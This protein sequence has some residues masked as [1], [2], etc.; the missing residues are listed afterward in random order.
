MGKKLLSVFF[1]LSIFF[2]N[3][4]DGFGQCPT[5]LNISA[6]PGTTI[7]AGTEV[8]FTANPNGGT[9]LQYQWQVNGDNVSTNASYQTSALTNGQK[10][11][12]IVTSTTAGFTDCSITSNE[13]TITVNSLKTPTVAVTANKT[14]ICPGENVTFTASNTNGGT[15]PQYSFYLNNGNTALQTGTSNTYSTT[16]LNNGDSIRVLLTSKLECVTS[17][18]AEADSNSITVRAGTPVKPGSINASV[19]TEICPGTSQ[20]YSIS[21]VAGAT[22]YQWTLPSGWSGTSTSTSINA[23]AGTSGGTISVKAINGCGT[24]EVETLNI[25][26]KPGTPAVPANITGETA[27]CPGSS[28]TY[29]IA[30]VTN[31]SEYIWILPSGWS[32][33]SNT[34]SI[35]VTAGNSGSGS[36]SI[37]AKNDCGTSAAK[38]L[39][40]SIK[41]GTPAQPGT[42]SGTSEI[43]PGTQQTYSITAITGATSYIWTL[44]NGW[45][46]TSTTNSITVTSGTTGGNVTVKATNDCGTG[47]EQTLP[48]SVK[49]GTPVQ[50][51]AFSG[52]NLVCPNTSETFSISP[53]NGATEY[54]W[55]LPSGWTGSSTSESITVTTGQSGSGNITVK[56]KNDCGT[57]TA[58]IYSV[59][60]DKPAPVMTGTVTGPVEVCSTATGLVYSIPAITNATTYTWSLPSGWAITAGEGTRSI[61]VKANSAG[62]NVSVI[63]KNTCGESAASANFVVTSITGV[64]NTPGTITAPNLPSSAICPPATGI[65]FNVPAV[66]GAKSY[67]WTL[68]SG[69]EITSGSGTNAIVVKVNS[70]AAT[71][72]NASI[73]VEAINVCGNSSKST[74]SGI[75]IDSH[76]ITN[77]GADKTVCKGIASIDITGT[78]SFSGS[79]ANLKTLWS[80]PAGMGSFDNASKLVTKFI[81]TQ[82]AL[83]AGSV[84]LT[85]TTDAPS[86]ACGPGK[87]EMIIYFKPLPTATITATSPVCNGS[88]STLTFTGTPNSRVT[89]KLPNGTNQ[90]VDIGASGTAT[91]TTAALSAN[92]TYTLISSVN[93]DSPACTFNFPASTST[94]VTITPKPTATISYAGVPFCTSLTTGQNPTFTGTGTGGTYSSTTGLAIN[95]SS[96]A[97]T[98]ST[99]TPMTYTV[100]YST[101]QGG[102]CAPVTATTQ[103]TITKAPT[104]AISYAGTPF[105]TSDSTAKPV[106]LTGTDGFSGGTFSAPAGLTINSSTGAITA[107]SSTAGTYLVTYNTPAAGGCAPLPFTTEVKI[108][109]APTVAISYLN[110]PFCLSDTSLKSVTITGTDVYTGGKYSAPSGLSINPSNGEINPAASASGTY[111]VTY[112]APATSGCGEVT[113]TTDVTITPTPAAQISYAGPFCNNDETPKAVTFSNTAGAYEGGSFSATTSGLSI[114][115]ATGEINAKNSSP[116]EYTVVYTIPTGNGCPTSEVSTKVVITSSPKVDISYITPLCS[117]DTAAYPV[118]FSNGSGAY[119][120]G[121]FSGTNGLAIDADGNISPGTSTPGVHTITYSTVAAGGCGTFETTTE[122]EIFK[123]VVITTEPVNLGICSTQPA[124]FEVVASGDNLTYLWKRLDGTSIIN[125]TGITSPKLNFTN[126]TS[127][128]AGE[129]FVEVSGSSPCSTVSSQSVSLNVDENIVIEEPLTEVPICG[130]GFSEVIMKFI[131]HAN[132][133]PLTFKWYK[134]NVVVDESDPNISI[135][136]DPADSNGR[137]TGT[138]TIKNVTT[139]YNGDYY[140]EVSGPDEFTCTT[141]VTNPFQLRLNE[142]PDLPVVQDLVVCQNETPE[143]FTVTSGTN[144]KWYLNEGDENHMVGGSGQPIAPTPPTDVP[145]DYFYWVTQQPEACE[146][147]KV[148]V[149]VTVKEKPSVPVLTSEEAVVE[150]CLGETAVPLTATGSINTTLNWYDS[151]TGEALASAPTPNTENPVEKFY[152]VSQ[153]PNDGFGCESERAL[154][155]VKVYPLP[156]VTASV[157]QEIICLGNPALLTATGGISYI[158]YEGEEVIGD[159]A[160]FSYTPS[161]A[162]NYIFKVLV[163]DNNGCQNSAEVNVQVDDNTVPGTLTGPL[164][165]C[166]SSP[167]GTLTLAGYTGNV[168]RWEKSIDGVAWTNIAETT[169]SLNFTNLTAAT[170][171]RAVVKNGVCGEL[172]SNEVSVGIDQLPV[173]GELNFAGTGR[174]LM[175]CEDPVGDYAVDL[176]LTNLQGVVAGW[177]YRAWD[178]IGYSPLIVDGQHFKGTTLTAD[179]IQSLNLS[180]TTVFQVEV[181]SG[182]CSPNALS[183][184]AIITVIPSDITPTPV[185]VDPGVVCLGEEV[186]LSSETGYETGGTLLDQG[187][188]D[189]ASITSH[190]WRIRREGLSGDLGF[191][192]DANNTEFDRWKRAT[193]RAFTTASI[194]PPYNTSGVTF[195]SGAEGNKGFGLISGKYNSTMETPIFTIGSMDQAVLTFDQ[196][197]V[198]TPG[199]FLKVE[200]STDGGNT[201]TT[202]YIRE[203][204]ADA[205]KGIQSGNFGSFGTGTVDTRPENKISLDLGDYIGRPNLRIRFNYS[206]AK[207]GNIWAVDNIDIPEGPNGITM[208]WRDYTDAN[209]PEGVLIGTN[210]TEKWSPT[211]VGL[212]IFEVKTKLIYNTNGDACAA[213]ENAQR[214]QVFVFDKYSTTVTAEYGSCGNFNA[215]LKATVVNSTGDTISTYPTPD[216]FIGQWT[217]SGSGYSLVDSNP[218]DTIAAINDPNAVL[219]TTGTGTFNVS[220][221]LTATAKNEAGVLYTNPEG[222]P[223][224][225][226]PIDVVIEGCST[227]DFDGED[228][229]VVIEHPYDDVVSIEA[230]IRPGETGGTI[231]S[232]PN[233]KITSPT[234]VT[235]N[236]RWYHIAVT[237]GRLYIDGIDT[238][239][240]SLGS[241]GEKTLIGAEWINGEATNFFSG[242]IEEVRLWKKTLTVEQ[243]HFMMNQRLIPN[244][245]Q[246]GEQIPMDVP[247]GLTY[248]D[249]AGYYRLISANPEPLTASPVTYLD[250][251]KPANGLTP[252][253]AT[254]KAPGRLMNM[255]TNQENTSPLPYFSG[256]DGTWETHATWLRPDVWDPPHTGDIEWNIVRTDHNI[257]SGDKDITVLGLKSTTADKLLTIAAPGTENEYNEGRALRV[258]HY[259]LLNGNIDLVGQSQLLQDPGSILDEASGGWLERDQQGKRNSFVYNYW[260]S[261]VSPQGTANNAPYSVGSVLFDGTFPDTPKTINFQPHHGAAD[262]P[263][264][265]PITTST[266][267]LWG[268][269]PATADEYSEWDHIQL[270]GTLETGEGFTMKGTDGGASITD[271]QN[272]TFRGK[273]HNGDFNLTFAAGQNYLIGNPYPSAFDGWEFIQNNIDRKVFDGSLYFWDHFKE[274]SH[275]LKE[276]VGGYG[277]LNLTS[278]VGVPAIAID[279][280]INPTDQIS[281]KKPTRYIAV[282]QGFMVNSTG[283][284]GGEISFKNSQ[285]TFKRD[286]DQGTSLILR[287]EIVTKTGKTKSNEYT[288]I[289]LSFSSPIGL[290]RQILV[291]A[292]PHTTNGFDLGYDAFLFDDNVEDMYFIQDKNFLVIQGVPHFNNDQ[293]LPLGV[294]IKENKPFTIRI[295]SLEN[296]PNG[297]KVY[298]N[299]KLNDS[300]HDLTS[301]PYNSTSEPGLIHDRFE[302][303][304]F[305][306][307]PPVIEVPGEEIPGEELVNLTITHAHDLR[308]IRIINPEEMA[309]TGVYLFGL[310]GNLI[311]SYGNLPNEKEVKLNVASYATGVYLIKVY[312]QGKIVTKKIIISN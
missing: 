159:G 227:L 109:K 116:G 231:I 98:P 294:K 283:V 252:D 297:M 255:E 62:G 135:I 155:T 312:A 14:S 94:T 38:T 214:V 122:L 66:T 56:A 217:I 174:V 201:Y 266:Y 226:T 91:V 286:G 196:A 171:F 212:N 298:L 218:N 257:H 45:T 195:D 228:D 137:Y 40:V 301:S 114:N 193:P 164:S 80:A 39:A 141:A 151:E 156:A 184:T 115:S 103:V 134:G 90:T 302:I 290:R 145:G 150:Y 192:T 68:P 47:T 296:A 209:N 168:I 182:V 271:E 93:L 146:S 293:I 127:A 246:M 273:P 31:A 260:S 309:I 126:A 259:L 221:T 21:A 185:T 29:S 86:G 213:E 208:E 111:S 27:V 306:E 230:W 300:I 48:V 60:V 291:G 54:I 215:L 265:N 281:G 183:K 7:C 157:E 92:S 46:G 285:R 20:T 202:L 304:F 274:V 106:T 64:P 258:T 144:L 245:A 198:L 24:G 102:G 133:A 167:T 224:I 108:T 97:I 140:V 261:P 229:V 264:S 34:N 249:L 121:T 63:A 101:P 276:Y 223:P 88:T 189:N 199:S 17:D 87:D 190:G 236:S 194:N 169:G 233:F 8:T 65:Q 74:L 232:G 11:R 284:S 50:P 280:R 117:S 84:V 58:A 19:G 99:S 43:C 30:A 18:T 292:I 234:D 22:S 310:N 41:P 55:T 1:L 275:I 123:E 200:I 28:Q 299:D 147:E 279:E 235:P 176:K 104:A 211:Q 175:V 119:E 242:W 239:A 81:P 42:I 288:K 170:R 158:W 35:T 132:G 59:S 225:V 303:V 186:T 51:G 256:S 163:T 287:P 241:G 112:T 69:W 240:L 57:G 165:V 308:Q 237:G 72:A 161:A 172:P 110:A 61:T 10:V 52:S 26:V 270:S 44:P 78:Y 149:K 206:G 251:D 219:S 77:A 118:T 25:T 83:D 32:G 73:S 37:Q 243:I 89:Y 197:Y 125:A 205:T 85:L 79:T 95:S 181:S 15:S 173:G 130:D 248:D 70:T 16:T 278:E 160:N 272:Y 268:Y 5:S 204:P 142:I 13:L 307:E 67:L 207:S 139:A 128:N 210:N 129:Y 143:E 4:L 105:C 6:A 131:A 36:I 180:K 262:G 71:T 154:I 9:N 96:G 124:S 82:A 75:A 152:W 191:D 220:W 238:K 289:R 138:L 222:C 53:V 2:L 263:R 216:R 120:G 166:V 179:Q 100:T 33:T 295:D 3:P 162:G 282:G 311:D 153:T 187:A 148:Q 254:T 113:A 247:G 277:V 23:T 178:A 267:W 244:G 177:Y 269:S 12:V 250:E 203:V 253:R 107:S 188:F 49:A 305:K 76:V 136:T